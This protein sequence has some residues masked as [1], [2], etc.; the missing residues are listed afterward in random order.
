MADKKENE[1]TSSGM[2]FTQ[3]MIIGFIIVVLVAISFFIKDKNL[4][5]SYMMVVGLLLFT[6]FNI[7]MTLKYYKKLRNAVGKQGPQGPRGPDGPQGEPGMCTFAESCGIDNAEQE[8]INRIKNKNSFKDHF[9]NTDEYNGCVKLL[10]DRLVNGSTKSVE[11]EKC[12]NIEQLV[13]EIIINAKTTK[14]HKDDY[15]DQVLGN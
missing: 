3:M 11:N 13:K 9:D 5:I 10:E 2:S 15:Y 4:R 1:N 12:K 6:L 8:T 14:V 7:S